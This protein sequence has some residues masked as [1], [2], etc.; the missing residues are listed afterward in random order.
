M[1]FPATRDALIAAGYKFENHSV[2]KGCKA[3]IEWYTTINGKKIPMDLMPEGT[4]K[5][6]PHWSTCPERDSFRSNVR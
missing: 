4:S 6:I 2:C 5:A 3:E 1:P